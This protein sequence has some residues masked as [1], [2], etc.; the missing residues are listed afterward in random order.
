MSDA[1]KPSRRRFF[2]FAEYPGH[3]KARFFHDVPTSEHVGILR[4]H[5]G[6]F[7]KRLSLLYREDQAAGA[8]HQIIFTDAPSH[9][10]NE[11]MKEEAY[12]S[13]HP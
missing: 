13:L 7:Q 3:R 6:R 9:K 2:S 4:Q 8:V 5:P 12:R 11:R 10:T 1:S